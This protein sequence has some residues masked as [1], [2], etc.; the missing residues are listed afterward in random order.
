MNQ[1]NV[2]TRNDNSV[3]LPFLAQNPR[4]PLRVPE[5]LGNG[6]LSTRQAPPLVFVKLQGLLG[7]TEDLL[8]T[9]SKLVSVGILA[10][11]LTSVLFP[12]KIH[13]LLLRQPYYSTLFPQRS[14]V[15][16]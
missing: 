16:R 2:S 4:L 9:V 10:A 11:V 8:S 15:C 13:V 3:C 7:T 14:L 1:L 5:S 6:I 12:P